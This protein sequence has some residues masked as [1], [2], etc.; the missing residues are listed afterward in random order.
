MAYSNALVFKEK[1]KISVLTLGILRSGSSAGS[2]LQELYTYQKL[3]NHVKT[4]Y[5]PL[6]SGV[7]SMQEEA[8]YVDYKRCLGNLSSTTLN[9]F[10]QVFLLHFLASISRFV[11]FGVFRNLLSRNDVLNFTRRHLAAM[12]F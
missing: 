1:S 2:R 7:S 9:I 12:T 10:I 11:I 4:F 6:I 3:L 5:Q 8:A